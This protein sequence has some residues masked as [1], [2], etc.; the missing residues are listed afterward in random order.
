MNK[1]IPIRSSLALAALLVAGQAMVQVTF[2]EHPDF[3]GR[4]FTTQKP[5]GNFERRGFNDRASSAIVSSDRW[6]V[7]EH[8]NYGGRC[9]VLRRGNYGSLAAMGLDDR[10]SS[11]RVVNKNARVDDD[12]YGPPPV[13]V[14]DARRRPNERLYEADVVAVRAVVGSPQQ[15]CW[16]EQEQV[17]TRGGAN[18]GG[19][20]IGA[21][22]GGILGHQ[23]GGGSGRD[24]ATAGGVLAGG[25][26][27]A[28]T[29]RDGKGATTQDV[30]R[31][32]TEPSQARPEYW[33]VTYTFR[34]RQHRAQMTSPPGRTVTV[35]G[36]GEP[37][38]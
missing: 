30:Q 16:V 36:Q 13:S 29:N 26:I 4:S 35:N 32:S 5:V 19:A 14:Y 23:I 6:E 7:C 31:C 20:V 3:Q 17:Q 18:V 15:R 2:Y 11:V 33:D 38:A 9:V 28:N 8:Q 1:N 37:R 27:G 12:R 10:V 22:I 25:A 21:V 24:I 34:G